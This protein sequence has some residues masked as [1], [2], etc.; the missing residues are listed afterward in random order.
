[1]KTLIISLLSLT[2]LNTHLFADDGEINTDTAR[3]YEAHLVTFMWPEGQS[4][5]QINYKNVLSTGNLLRLTKGEE[6]KLSTTSSTSGSTPFGNIEERL[7]GHV[8][9]LAN[10]QW[11]LIFN[12]PGDT[13]SKTFHSEQEKDGYPELTGSISVKL[14]RY[15]E[16]DIRYQHYLFD[17]FTQPNTQGQSGKGSFFSQGRNTLDTQPEFK[18]F[19]PALVLALNQRN[20]TASKKV[21]Y[22]DH[23]TIGTLLYFEPI[24]LEDAMDKIALLSM[25][26]ET[27]KSLNYDELQST[28]ELSLK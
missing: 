20:K 26:P 1:M 25:M 3:A 12:H 8:K 15:L 5:E 9:I 28:N 19:D 14:G 4:S 10:Q 2:L 13:I 23:P 22:L 11:T 18:E 21:N 27:G 6:D 16:S 7:G 24:E 17:S